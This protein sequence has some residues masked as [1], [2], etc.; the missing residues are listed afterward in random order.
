MSY[1]R[2]SSANWMCDLYCYEDSSGGWTTHVASNR[3]LEAPPSDRY[4]DFLDGR[5]TPEEFTA[6][7]RAQ[8][9]AL[10]RIP[11][12][13]IDLPH[14]GETFNDT[15]LEEFKERLLMLRTAGYI[16]PDYVLDDVDREIA[17]Q[18]QKGH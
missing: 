5:I 7:H 11:L 6:L 15:S 9:D 12:V 8:L 18:T 4:E 17:E 14:V 16:F 2:W 1:C 13:S 3:R 10:E